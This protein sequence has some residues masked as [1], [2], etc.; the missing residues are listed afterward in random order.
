MKKIL[1]IMLVFSLVLT[2]CSE[3]WLDLNPYSSVSDETA[4]SD[5]ADAQTALYGVY[6]HIRH[7]TFYGRDAIICGDAGTPDV[8]LKTTNSNRFVVEYSWQAA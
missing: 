2:S 3:E 1:T 8:V 7:N 6:Y 4:I 5:L